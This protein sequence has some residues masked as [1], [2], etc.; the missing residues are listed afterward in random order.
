MRFVQKHALDGPCG[1][2]GENR[3]S[4]DQLGL[5]LHMLAQDDGGAVFHELQSRPG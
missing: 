2:I 1:S 5:R 3:G 4:S